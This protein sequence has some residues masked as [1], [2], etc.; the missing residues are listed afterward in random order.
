VHYAITNQ[1]SGGFGAAF[2]ITNT[3][4]T[5]INGWSLKFSFANGQTI[6]QG[7]NGSFAQ[8]GSAV[9]ITNAS[10]NGSIP[11][12]SQASNEPGFNGSWNGT[13]AAPTAFT[14][15]GAACGVV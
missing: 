5:A 10:Y 6:T 7:W 13:N 12:G 3:G 9:T 4:T 8:S 1:W 14:L 11:A 2:T 15:N